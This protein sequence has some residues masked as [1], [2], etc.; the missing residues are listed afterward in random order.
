LTD[1]VAKKVNARR[2]NVI[3]VLLSINQGYS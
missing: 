2:I 3:Q 1:G